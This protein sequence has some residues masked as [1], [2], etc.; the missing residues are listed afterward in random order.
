MDDASGR[1]PRPAE[2]V[3][4]SGVS[5]MEKETGT[6]CGHNSGESHYM[7]SAEGA[8]TSSQ[9]L[10]QKDR[11]FQRILFEWREFSGLQST[12]LWREP[13]IQSKNLI[14]RH[15]N[16]ILRQRAP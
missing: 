8:R 5:E 11:G 16:A 3:T 10:R 14:L 2:G 1:R 6:G 12:S 13:P 4:L 9:S 7:V 15:H